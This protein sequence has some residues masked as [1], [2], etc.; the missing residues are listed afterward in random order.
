VELV[1]DRFAV[2]DDGHTV[3][4]SSGEDVLLTTSS[5]GDRAEQVRWAV[6]C[7]GFC[8]VDHRVIARLVDYGRIGETERFEAWRSGPPWRGGRV[9]AERVLH[10]AQSFLRASALTAGAPALD[11]VRACGTRPVV[12]PDAAAGYD[13]EMPSPV[14][15]AAIS[16]EACGISVIER[17]A[18]AALAEL[19]AQRVGAQPR[20]VALWG[21]RGAGLLTAIG[22]LSRVARVNGFVPLSLEIVNARILDALRGRSLFLIDRPG[23]AR[24]WRGLVDSS[25]RSPRSHVLLLAGAEEV[26]R[27]QGV[28]LERLMPEALQGAIRPC[29][30]G[31]AVRGRIETAARR[32]DGWPGHFARLLWGP[33]PDI[34]TSR[35]SRGLTMAAE[36]PTTYGKA[37]PVLQDGAGSP[38]AGSWPASGELTALRRRM[39]A[40]I[41]HVE[42]GRH[43]PG[44]RALRQAVGGLTRRCDWVHAAR[45]GLVLASSLLKRGRPRD[46]QVVLAE[47]SESATKAGQDGSMVDVAVLAGAAWT[48]LARLDEAES[49]LG[50]AIEAA[51]SRD[52]PVRTASS[53]L[54]LA[55]CLFWR[56]RYSEADRLL[57]SIEIRPTRDATAVRLEI[58]ASRIAIGRG[59]LG[60]AV[61]RA[62]SA[63]DTAECIN[64]PSII[65]QAACGAAFAHLSV[66]DR[67][68]VERDVATSVRAA[69]AA[70]DPL[71]ALRA[72]LIG[73]EGARRLG[74]CGAAATLLR[75]VG[76]MSLPPTLRARCAL[77][78][79]LLSSPS[80]SEVVK[81]HASTTGLNALALFAPSA[82]PETAAGLRSA[83]DDLV[84]ILRCCHTADEDGSVLREVCARLRSRLRA[85]A[86]GFFALDRGS[87]VPLA[88]DGA[89]IEAAIV[90]RACA[91]GQAIAPHACGERIEG[92]APVRYAGETLGT[93]VARWTLGT[94]HDLPRASMVL[95]MAAT[96]A[97]PAVA[98]A[99]ARRA[100]PPRPGVDELLGVSA[101]MA[102]VRQALDRA[103]GAPFAVLIEGESGSGKELVARALHRC[104][105]RRD[106]SFCALNCAALP[107]DLVEAELFGHAR[108]AFTGAFAERPGVFEEA[109]TGTLF[110]DEIGEL[111]LRA[112]AK[113]LRTIQEGELRRVGENV[114][115][116]IDVRIVSASNRDL[117]QDVTAG[118]FRL[119]LLYRLDVIRITLPPLRDRREDIAILAEAFWRDVAARVG[120]RATLGTATIA[121]LARYDWPGNA[122][123]LQNVLAALAVRSAKR[124]VIPPT[125]LGPN[126]DEAPPAAWR[127]D[128]A[129]RTFE[130]RFV[131]AAL[132][133]TGGHRARAAGELGVTRQGLTKLMTRLG[134]NTD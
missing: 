108:G 126:F 125:A 97:G 83:V 80:P 121:A 117:R 59:D 36:Q 70:R 31:G 33:A 113:V 48:D 63:L 127:L 56:G 114:S 74:R 86:I 79:D 42:G 27:V 11:R 28:Q 85:A 106:R 116:R 4:L 115:R 89:R 64:T 14:Q 37:L 120:S 92:A 111:S 102:E 71:R 105:P 124:G 23:T 122:R 45:G 55:R 90:E 134:I 82:T 67:V 94:P 10:V 75:R 58:A 1:A 72:R 18:V 76:K 41:R 30:L 128:D 39:D 26:P 69:R 99:L 5:A 65:A 24:G 73:A 62:T 98:A 15:L 77:L 3:D 44:E 57:S 107:D 35:A 60:G 103:A 93:L 84:E 53:A 2:M 88:T 91:A 22:E 29:G 8:R 13:A 133:R 109:H 100:Q 47:T 54:A 87:V 119:D 12:L 21:P 40:A 52:E 112:Q 61:S 50:A 131:R 46:A 123:E 17:R 68:A 78:T 32:S 7:E 66:G 95:T 130:E 19:F 104:S 9:E 118:R 101:P 96:A 51:R 20:V 6:R 129:R 25:L 49:V 38:E 81:R 16:V 43:A 132:V 110:L 34:R